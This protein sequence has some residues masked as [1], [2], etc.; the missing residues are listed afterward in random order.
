M[1]RRRRRPIDDLAAL[2]ERHLEA[3]EPTGWFEP[4]Y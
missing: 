4:L 3:G 1:F 2:V